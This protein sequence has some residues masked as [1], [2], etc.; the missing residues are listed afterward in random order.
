MLEGGNSN[1]TLEDFDIDL[2]PG[3]D[4]DIE[5][6]GLDLGIDIEGLPFDIDLGFSA[7]V[8][9]EGQ[10]SGGLDLA[11]PFGNGAV[12]LQ[13]SINTNGTWNVNLGGTFSF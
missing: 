3:I 7:S 5:N 10:V 11:I 1:P 4:F 2:S 8:D 6:P 9:L 13:A 12:D